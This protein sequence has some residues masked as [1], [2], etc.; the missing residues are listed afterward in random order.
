MAKISS[1]PEELLP[2]IFGYITSNI[3]LAQC[4]LVCAKW[5]KPAN[6]AMFSNTIVFGTNEKVLALHGRLFSDPAKGKLVQHIYFKENFDAFWVAKAI[7]NTAFLPNVNS[8]QGSVS[9]PEEF[10]EMLL[11][12]AR[13]SPNALKKLKCVTRIQEDF[14]RNAYQQSRGIR[15]RGYDRV[16][17]QSQHRSQ[18]EKLK[19]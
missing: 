1:L 17:T 3:Q 2:K 12:I 7:L 19:T 6:S 11:S 9:K 10:Y 15:E 4:R 14:S 8:F 5:N 18:L 13:E 16:H